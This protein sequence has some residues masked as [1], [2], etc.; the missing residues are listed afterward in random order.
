MA[1]WWRPVK[2]PNSNAISYLRRQLSTHGTAAT[3][4]QCCPSHSSCA[5]STCAEW[6]VVKNRACCHFFMEKL[7][8]AAETTSLIWG[9][10][11]WKRKCVWDHTEGGKC[12]VEIGFIGALRKHS[13]R[14]FLISPQQKTK[15][16]FPLCR[17]SAVTFIAQFLQHGLASMRHC[18][19]TIAL[20]LPSVSREKA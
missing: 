17:G 14:A 4:W 12:A 19:G 2:S 13:Y 11:F 7:L 10:S 3:T 20:I 15:C 8:Q 6:H 5:S 18:R 9:W 1:E 16:H